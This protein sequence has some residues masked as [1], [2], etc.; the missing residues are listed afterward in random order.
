M[1]L[2]KKPENKHEQKIKD[3][4]IRLQSATDKFKTI[5]VEEIHLDKSISK[6]NVAD[7]ATFLSDSKNLQ[8]VTATP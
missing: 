8:K 5:K 7:L 3:A 1:N 4:Y 2:I 6:E